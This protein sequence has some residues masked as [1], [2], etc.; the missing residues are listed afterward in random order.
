MTYQVNDSTNIAIYIEDQELP[1]DSGNS[2]H[3]LHVVAGS[4]ITLP[5]LQFNFTDMLKVVPFMKLQDGSLI[6]VVI[7]GI[8]KTQRRFRVLNWSRTSI[9]D[10]F[11]YTVDAYWDAPKFWLG[12]TNT[13]VRG[14][15]YTVLTDLAT[16][17]GIKAHKGNTPTNDTM[18]WVP[19]NATYGQFSRAIARHGYA[20]PKS[21]MVFAVDTLGTMRYLDVST[22]PAPDRT[23]GY[24]PPQNGTKFQLLTDFKPVNRSGIANAMSGYRHTRHVQYALGN[25]IGPDLVE[26][27]VTTVPD[28]KYPLVNMSVRDLQVRGSISYSPVDFGNVHEHYE[29]ALYQNI[30]FNMLNSVEGEFLF[31]YQTDWEAGDNFTYVS[32]AELSNKSYDGEFTVVTK[33]VFITGSTYQ[34]KVIAVKQG[35]ESGS[36]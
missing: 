27:E 21:L 5:M 25:S 9:G 4:R 35:L 11:N 15:S 2:L 12:S 6:T 36:K 10:G 1:L 18:L 14:S 28:S 23:V 8:I 22:N 33:V 13:N 3:M 26:S 34:E 29:R 32:P 31:S 17:C 16:E 20:N 24:T 19:G 30:R 7:D